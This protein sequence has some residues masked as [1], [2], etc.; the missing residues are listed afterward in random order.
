MTASRKLLGN[1]PRR[2]QHGRRSFSH[3]FGTASAAPV[4]QK[5]SFSGATEKREVDFAV[6]SGGRLEL[7]EAKWTELLDFGYTVNLDVVRI[8]IR[9]A[10]VSTGCVVS[11]TPNT[12]AFPNGFRALP[13]TEGLTC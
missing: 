6:D 4:A 13:V 7:F 10:C 3:N 12:F 5:A 8:V 1:H 11:R 9:E 2:A